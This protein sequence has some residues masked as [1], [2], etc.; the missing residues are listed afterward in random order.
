MAHLLQHCLACGSTELR[1]VLSLGNQALAN[2][3]RYTEDMSPEPTFPL[4]LNRCSRCFHC[5]LG[6]AV[7]PHLLYRNYRYVSGTTATLRSYFNWF[8][9]RLATAAPNARS[10]L[11]L[12][13]ND[14][15]LLQVL[16]A[17]GYE[18]AGV[19]PAENLH[20]VTQAVGLDVRC[21]YWTE[22]EAKALGRRFDVLIA[23]N[24]VA[25]GAEPLDFL[26]ACRRTLQPGGKLFV[27]TSQAFMV[28]H[29]EFDTI[30][31]EHHSFFTTRSMQALAERAA[32]RV[33]EAEHVPVHGTS[34]LY[35]LS[36]DAPAGPSV[37][38][39]L[40]DEEA[41]GLYDDSTYKN[42]AAVAAAVR[43]QLEDVVAEHKRQGFRILAYGAAA[44]G[45]TV[46]Q[47]AHGAGVEAVVDDNVLKHGL[48][49]PGT[50][51]PVLAPCA[52]AAIPHPVLH[53]ITAWN[54]RDEIVRRIR[55]VRH[56][57]SDRFLVYFPSVEVFA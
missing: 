13:C 9:N 55:A 14:G 50:G 31:H 48:C 10:I 6:V 30:Y 28:D 42:F 52:L 21:A 36:A 38:A 5:Q 29:G 40:A 3:Y 41:R 54:F 18:V 4:D 1:P 35:T 2:A 56:G 34:L 53:V 47:F 49:L 39:M 25:H 37:A 20:S 27:Q 15:T 17:C 51:L 57:A 12:A 16:R 26:R 43:Q 33:V 7:D 46:L 23:M 8:A 44:K 11:E 19:D 32:L 45:N 24:V 22:A